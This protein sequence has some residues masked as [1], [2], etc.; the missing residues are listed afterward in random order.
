MAWST[1]KRDADRSRLRQFSALSPDRC[2]TVVCEEA[3]MR[4]L[5][6]EDEVRLADTVRR[7]LDAEGFN[8]DVVNNGV[9]GLW[10]PRRTPTP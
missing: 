3:T 5:M 7:S 4:V 1:G 2:A 8:I 9:D 10:R 6:V